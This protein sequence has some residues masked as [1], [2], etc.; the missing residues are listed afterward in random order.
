MVR[1]CRLLTTLLVTALLLGSHCV[2][3]ARGDAGAGFLTW[4]RLPD[5]PADLGV[6]GPFVGVSDGV[7]IVAGGANFP[8]PTWESD[9]AYHDAVHVMRRVDGAWTWSGGGRL[10]API[11]YGVSVSTGRGVVCVGGHSGAVVSGA[12]YVL[13]W[14]DDGE[15]VLTSPLPDLPTPTTH[16]AGVAFGNRVWIFGGQ[17]GS[18]LSTATNATWVLDLDDE[19]PRWAAGP[20]CPGPTRALA[21]AAVQHDGRGDR[22]YLMS[23]RRQGAR[24]VELLTDVWVLDPEPVDGPPT[25]RSAA[26]LPRCVMAGTAAP[27]GTNH[28][29]VLGGDDGAHFFK[30]LGAHHPGFTKRSLLYHAITDTWTEG[31]PTPINQVTTWAVALDGGVVVPSGEIRP[32]VRTRDVWQVRVRESEETFG[33]VDGSV[34]AVYLLGMLV[35]GF[36]FSRAGGGTDGFFRGGQ[37][38]PAWAV[39]L[40]I[41]ATMLSS[42]TFMAIPAKAFATD[43]TYFLGNVM[44]LAAV[45]FVIRGYLPFFRRIDATS[46]YEYLEKRFSGP[47]RLVGSAQFVAYQVARMAI[48][49][50]LPALAIEVITP[51]DRATCILIMGGLSIAYC[52]MGGIR[53]VIWT[54]VVQTIVLLGGALLTLVIVVFDV[55]F[56]EVLASASDADKFRIANDGWS[57]FDVVPVLWVVVVGQFLSNIVQYGSDQTVVQRYMSTETE[58][59]AA[60]AI[61]SNGVLSVVA[62]VLFF[63]VGTALWAFYRDHPD[64]LDPSFRTDQ[65]F[66]LFISRELPVGIA[67]L[68][69]AGILAAAQSTIS[70]SMNSVATVLVTDWYR[71]FRPEGSDRHYLVVGRG[72]TVLLGVVGTVAA[73]WFSTLESRSLLD[74]FLKYVGLLT[75]VLGGLFLLGITS[76]RAHAAGALGGAVVGAGVLIAV[77]VS[78]VPVHFFLYAGIGMFATVCSGVLISVA[79]PGKPRIEGLTLRS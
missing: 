58:Q 17:T 69:V 37:R 59:K 1:S 40:S 41:F 30:N 29:A 12:A 31:G 3:Q 46:A 65:I 61:L 10:P 47:V 36:W 48:V 4:E 56:G 19:T 23:G 11:G 27:V 57:P 18:D 51:L 77:S 49:L 33:A 45:P 8:A 62:S 13:T 32:R 79:I 53:A 71:R 26:D 5:L 64:R 28:I 70:T 9:K 54:D 39:S 72:L 7:L 73:L 42:I 76:R 74:E 2:A 35:I 60:R 68:V 20:P 44:I 24:G 14:N 43:W 16:A 52:T 50:L 78:E 34:V 38:V 6:A 55:G 21:V 63:G 66:P 22:I 15:T 75:S 25:W 67:G